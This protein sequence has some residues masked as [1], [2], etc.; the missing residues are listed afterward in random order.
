MVVPMSYLRLP[1][2]RQW[3][4]RAG[5]SQDDLA[6]LAGISRSTVHNA[7]TGAKDVLPSTLRSLARALKLKPHELQRPP[8]E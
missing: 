3:R 5:L 2:L 4:L 6:E 8:P 1:H 7:E